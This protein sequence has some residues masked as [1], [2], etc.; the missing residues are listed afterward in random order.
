M[1]LEVSG[2]STS[3]IV[4]E[5]AG[6]LV[7]IAGKTTA[8]RM[9]VPDRELPVQVSSIPQQLLQAQGVNDMVTA[10]RNASGVSANRK[11]GMYEYYTV[12]GSVSVTG[13]MLLTACAWKDRFN[14]SQASTC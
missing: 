12:R 11:W 4:R 6:T 5:V 3:I 7:D 13:G 2:I 14:T 10:L 9:V 8:S 1:I